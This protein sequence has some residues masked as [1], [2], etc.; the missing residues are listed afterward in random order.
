MSRT[1]ANLKR[2]TLLLMVSNIGGALLS[3][4]LSALIGR[5][6]GETG[7][8]VYAVSAAWIF[9]LALI[10]DFGISTLMTR[11]LAATPEDCE[12]YLSASALARGLFGGLLVISLFLLAPALSTDPQV[13]EGIRISA[14]LIVILPFYSSF[15]A[16]FKARDGMALIPW[17]NIG[18][19]TAQVVLTVIVFALGSGVRAAIVV[20]VITSLGQLIAAYLAYRARYA[21]SFSLTEPLPPLVRMLIRRSW[22]FALAG[23]LAAMQIRLSTILLE[24]L[25]SAGEVGY[26]SAGSRFVEAARLIPNAYFG[27]LFPALSAVAADP[28]AMQR[29]FGGA[30]RSLALFSLICVI[31]A[32]LAAP[33][34]IPWVFGSAFSPAIPVLQVLMLALGFGVVR[35]LRTLYWYAHEREGYVNLVNGV[36]IVIQAA[37]SLLLMPG[38]GA[39]GA[40]IALVVVEL[41]ALLL[42]WREIPVSKWFRGL[43]RDSFRASSG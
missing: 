36:V 6:L 27:A 38:L 11:D 23:L 30:V 29:V 13:I 8:G 25:S 41:V 1:A 4:A 15:T 7:L 32:W 39:L 18:M 10:A 14:P 20:N 21:A 31:S 9:P 28:S 40:A 26:F 17:L 19:L 43:S 5:A 16:V 2:N 42:L 3:F 34:V 37:L 12:R 22:K 33:F 35:G 24:R